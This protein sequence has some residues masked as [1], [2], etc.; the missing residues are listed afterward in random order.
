MILT[1]W[2]LLLVEWQTRQSLGWIIQAPTVVSDLGSAEHLVLS[3][4]L[5]V[6]H[7]LY[8]PNSARYVTATDFG[9]AGHLIVSRILIVYN[10]SSITPTLL[11]M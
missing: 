9:F 8:Y 6:Q 5:S 3:M 2:A 7:M 4:I 11:V 1:I 10:I